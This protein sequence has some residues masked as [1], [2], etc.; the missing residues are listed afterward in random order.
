MPLSDPAPRALQHTRNLELK[1]YQRE[2]ELWDI[3]G[4]ITDL[5]EADYS[6]LDNERTAD[7]PVHDMWLRLTIDTDLVV[8][9]AE[10]QMDIGAHIPCPKAAPNYSRLKGLKMGPGWNKAV[11]ERLGGVMGCTHLNEMLAQMA[12]TAMQSLFEVVENMQDQGD[13]RYYLSPGLRNSCYAYALNSTYVRDYF[14]DFYEPD[15]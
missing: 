8:Q 14:P 10:A 5:K 9:E 11:R 4:H 6:M 2:D 3:E 12:T 1:A 13:G 15:S 7:Q